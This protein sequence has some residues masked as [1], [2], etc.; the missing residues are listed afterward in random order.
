MRHS[1]PKP[2]ALIVNTS[3]AGLIEPGALVEALRRG[4]PGR[5]AVDVYEEEPV[6]NGNHPLLKLPNVICTPHLGYVEKESY[7]LYFS[8]AFD[9]VL[10][11]LAGTPSNVVNPKALEVDR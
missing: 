9:N 8:S 3:R 10:N 6:L 4:R 7:E 2:T 11:F 5:A 1:V